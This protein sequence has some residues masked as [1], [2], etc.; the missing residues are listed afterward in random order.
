MQIGFGKACCTRFGYTQKGVFLAGFD[1]GSIF[2]IFKLNPN[3]KM[4]INFLSLGRKYKQDKC[5]F[6][7]KWLP[8]HRR[9]KKEGKPISFWRTDVEPYDFQIFENYFINTYFVVFQVL[10]IYVQTKML[11]HLIMLTIDIQHTYTN[12]F[13]DFASFISNGIHKA[14]L[15]MKQHRPIV[16]F[17]WHSLLRH[18]L[19]YCGSKAW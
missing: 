3:A 7:V 9:E 5:S 2:E 11:V 12:T 17:R 14:L 1:R 4:P 10:G 15:D 19:L 6:K 13:F 18:I 16:H 8:L